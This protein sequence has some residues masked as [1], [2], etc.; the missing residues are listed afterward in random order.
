MTEIFKLAL[1]PLQF[2]F[3]SIAGSTIPITFV[4]VGSTT[5][6]AASQLIIT[7]T[8]DQDLIFCFDN[9][10]TDELHIPA[11]DVVPQLLN[12]PVGSIG[13]A[14]RKGTQISVRASIAALAGQ[15]SITLV[16]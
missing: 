8:V 2:D 3:K 1:E 4:P 10:L 6:I 11:G 5:S 12:W 14:L 7:S 9:T 13:K 15:L 16:G